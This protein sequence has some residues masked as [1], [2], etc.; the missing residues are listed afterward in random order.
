MKTKLDKYEKEI[1]KSI[2]N[3][4]WVPVEN[5][6]E[7]R[8]KLQNAARNTMR[9]DQRM[10]IRIA[11]RDIDSLKVKALEEGMPYQTLVSSIL[12]K[13]ISGKLIEKRS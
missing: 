13:Y 12:H 10:N 1:I 7:L 3:D 9:K 4:E 5:S 2:E 11:K 8:K 6:K